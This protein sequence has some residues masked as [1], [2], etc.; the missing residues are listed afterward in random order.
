MS[1]SRGLGAPTT[2]YR[3]L[4]TIS[5]RSL[6]AATARAACCPSLLLVLNN[7]L[8]DR[9]FT[10]LKWAERRQMERCARTKIDAMTK[11][12]ASVRARRWCHHGP[13]PSLPRPGAT[14]G[15]GDI[16]HRPLV[17]GADGT[18]IRV[19]NLYLLDAF[20]RRANYRMDIGA[21][22]RATGSGFFVRRLGCIVQIQKG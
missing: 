18:K 13:T 1:A 22:R 21:T 15:Q 20:G 6:A 14:S 5:E 7:A 8:R 16:F 17:I 10:G 19:V 12:S 9:E 4:G 11:P 3:G 2:P